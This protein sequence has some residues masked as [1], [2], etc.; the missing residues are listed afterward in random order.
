[1]T[2][3]NVRMLADA[4]EMRAASDVFRVAVHSP[5]QS[6][7]KWKYV[8]DMYEPGRV[9]GAFS[10]GAIVGTTMSFLSSLALPGGRVES[11]AAVTGVGVRTDFRRRGMLTE[12][13]R[14]QLLAS[15]SAGEMFA[16]LHASEGAIYGRFGYGIATHC[17]NLTVSSR[18]AQIRPEVPRGGEI[19]LVDKSEAIDLL[20]GIYDRILG[21]RP[22]MMGRPRG[23]WSMAYG[24]RLF[25]TDDELFLIGVHTGPDGLDGFVAYEVEPSNSQDSEAKLQVVDFV[26]ANQPAA[27]DLWRFLLGVDLV[28]EV[29]TWV[30]AVDDPIQAMLVDQFVSRSTLDD[31]LWIRLLDIPAALAARSYGDAEPIVLEVRDSLLPNNSG[32]YRISPQGTERVSAPAD[33]ALTSDALAMIYLGT[34]RASSLAGVGRIQVT[35]PAALRSADRLF[36][37]EVP[38]WCGTMF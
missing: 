6:D 34:T 21:Q 33:L 10:A 28:G 29:H 1:V 37:T 14:T 25:A 35:N 20:S 13:M 2:D 19:R 18:R 16:G 30:T 36:A 17:R 7:E 11:M 15:A 31:D 3:F 22:G 5:P 24:R 4:A 27:N 23:W 9:F 12:L 8:S 38:A 32:C 26:V